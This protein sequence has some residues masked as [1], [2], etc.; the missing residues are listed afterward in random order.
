MSEEYSEYIKE[1]YN[2]IA[3]KFGESYHHERWMKNIL[4]RRDYE[5]TLKTILRFV[6]NKRFERALEIGCGVGTWTAHFSKICEELRILD[7]SQNMVKITV[8]KLHKIGFYNVNY[9]VGDFQNSDLKVE[10]SYD[11][12]FSIRAIEY[13]QNKS[14][15]LSRI[16]QL[17]KEGGIA[18]I[19]TKNPNV[20]VIPF[21][22]LLTRRILKPPKLFSQLVNY[23]DL[24]LIAKKVGFDDVSAYPVII[25]FNF[26][27]LSEWH[28]KIFSDQI[29]KA[30]WQ[31]RISPAFL[32]QIESYAIVL[33]R[34][35]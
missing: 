23:K 12:I 4:T 35:N 28:K 1:Y 26:P 7:I 19:V 21:T 32:T 24:L 27:F 10:G 16:H 18:L 34:T 15:V 2:N 5:Q 17:L 6:G 8:D 29:H 22:F 33:K 3:K 14:Y 13:M 25:S 31:R 9:I 30:I 20:G 11:A